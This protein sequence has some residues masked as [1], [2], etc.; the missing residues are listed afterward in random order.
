[1]LELTEDNFH[2]I[3]LQSEKPILVDFW[4]S[5][6]GPC[7]QMLPILESLDKEQDD[8]IIA[9]VDTVKY[10][11]LAQR[12]NVDSLPTFVLFS[13]DKQ[14]RYVGVKSKDFFL[15]EFKRHI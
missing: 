15:Q 5:W 4:A 12:Y 13:S 8:V 2:E 9:K 1:M 3:L 6:C 14:V 10:A 11:S 7:R